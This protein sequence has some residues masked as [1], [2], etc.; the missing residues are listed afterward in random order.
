MQN[1]HRTPSCKY[2]PTYLPHYVLEC[3]ENKTYPAHN[4]VLQIHSW[5]VRW[6]VHKGRLTYN[7]PSTEEACFFSARHCLRRPLTFPTLV[8]MQSLKHLKLASSFR[9]WENGKTNENHAITFCNYQIQQLSNSQ[10]SRVTNQSYPGSKPSGRSIWQIPQQAPPTR[11]FY[12][13]FIGYTVYDIP[14]F[15][16]M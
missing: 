4:F 11:C 5:V 2:I 9:N 16:M 3:L 8:E 15:G 14:L 13:Y 6:F 10:P 12:F 7:F 1:G